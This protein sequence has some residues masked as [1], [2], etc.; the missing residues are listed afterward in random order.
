MFEKISSIVVND[1]S[2][3]KDKVFLTFDIDWANDDIIATAID[4]VEQAGVAATWFVTHDT[5]L[6]KRLR[7]NSKFELGIHP[8]FNFLLHGDPRNGRTAVEVIDRL[9]SLVPEAKAVRSHCLTQ[10]S[11]L[12]DMFKS[13]GL[14]YDCNDFI[15]AH[16]KIELKPWLLW[17][18]MVRAPHFWE[19][20]VG[21]LYGS[22]ESI[23]DLVQRVGLKIFDFHPIHVFLNTEHL[24][25]YE[26]TR[27]FHN[28]P[29]E[30]VSYQFSGV[31]TRSRL[32]DL[33]NIR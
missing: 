26:R 28:K 29:D 10:G 15:S 32:L 25:R 9:M 31:G 19:D 14:M 22:H 6:L 5:P 24:D 27:A 33:L 30:L 16:T 7:S 20:D 4:L 3:W 11:L 21:C 8:N 23:D 2:T 1:E 17:N 18:G 13:V 12:L